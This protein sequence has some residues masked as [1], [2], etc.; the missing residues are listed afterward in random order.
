M[1]S[2]KIKNNRII[3]N[4]NFISLFLDNHDFLNFCIKTLCNQ[5][6]VEVDC[7]DLLLSHNSI[8]IDSLGEKFKQTDLIARN[9]NDIINIEANNITGKT[10]RM[11]NTSYIM[12]I[13][14]ES[15][16]RG[17]LYNTNKNFLQIN[18]DNGNEENFGCLTK[19]SILTID[20]TAIINNF[21]LLFLDVEKCYEKFY[22]LIKEGK[23]SEIDN[24]IRI[25]AFFYSNDPNESDAILGNMLDIELKKR[26]I[27]KVREMYTMNDDYTLTKEAADQYGEFLYYGWKHEFTEDGKRIGRKQ[28]RKQGRKEGIKEGKLAG[29][30]EKAIEMIKGMLKKEISYND[31]SDIS[32]KTVEEI[33]EIERSMK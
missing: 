13:Y 3:D 32:G 14:S 26:V 12:K 33:K 15:A 2:K 21:N 23:E 20:G 19:A 5:E 24:H 6:K 18:F 17:G 10:T 16:K 28:G 27:G 4:V 9:N 8:P 11:K 25:G 29:L 22:N 30:K 31:I 1:T 7:N